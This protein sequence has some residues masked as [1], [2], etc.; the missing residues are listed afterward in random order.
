MASY[1]EGVHVADEFGILMVCMFF[2]G[3][4]SVAVKAG[5]FK[6]FF[7]GIQLQV[8]IVPLVLVFIVALETDAS[9]GLIGCAP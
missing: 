3:Y 2:I 9:H 8:G 1:T 4:F 7:F 5:L 6:N